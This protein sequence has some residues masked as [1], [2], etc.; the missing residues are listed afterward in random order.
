MKNV[1]KIEY[2]IFRLFITITNLLGMLGS[3]KPKKFADL[4]YSLLISLIGFRK[5]Y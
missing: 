5:D 4:L 2:L 1:L 3:T